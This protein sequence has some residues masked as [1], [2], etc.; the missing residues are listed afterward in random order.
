MAILD[1][2]KVLFCHRKSQLQQHGILAIVIENMQD[3][4]NLLK[5]IARLFET[6]REQ[7]K[8]LVHE[9]VAGVETRLTAKID[10]VDMKVEAFN[11]KLD[12]FAKE[13]KEEITETI[14]REANASAELFHDTFEKLDKQ[15]KLEER[16]ER[17]EREL[18][19]PH[20]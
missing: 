4:D 20:I 7:T 3:N 1:K 17:V 9:E 19:L 6:E 16:M 15:E 18:N 11:H 8:K 12:V 14:E 5:Q 2:T 13:I 10:T